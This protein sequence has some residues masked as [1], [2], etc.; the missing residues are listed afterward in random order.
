M[1]FVCMTDCLL[2]KAH[3]GLLLLRPRNRCIVWQAVVGSRPGAVLVTGGTGALG[4]AVAGWLPAR[5][6]RRLILASRS[7]AATPAVRQLIA[8]PA[9]GAMVTV[10]RADVGNSAQAELAAAMTIQV[11]MY[12]LDSCSYNN[13]LTHWLQLNEVMDFQHG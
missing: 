1:I 11:S 4:T 12:T 7:G 2:E 13:S 6:A 8:G 3:S 9:F 10:A 5:G